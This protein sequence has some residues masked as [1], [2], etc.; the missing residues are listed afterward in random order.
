MGGFAEFSQPFRPPNKSVM[1][2]LAGGRA[3]SYE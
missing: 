1:P 3:I 2:V